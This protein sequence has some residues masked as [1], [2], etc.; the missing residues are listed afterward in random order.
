M[1]E[2]LRNTA[3][4]APESLLVELLDKKATAASL[5][6]AA[7]VAGRFLPPD[8]CVKPLLALLKHK[9]P[10]AREGALLGLSFHL[11]FDG[12]NEAVAK[13]KKNDKSKAVRT[14][15]GRVLNCKE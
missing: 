1:D 6:F 13:V 12:V 5:T 4:T 2:S 10:L 7:E 11:D 8:L 3:L 9:Q 15:A 14:I